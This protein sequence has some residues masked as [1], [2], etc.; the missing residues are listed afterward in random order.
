ML[1]AWPKLTIFRLR[2]IPVR[3]DATFLLVPVFFLGGLS[4]R[5]IEDGA[6][7][8]IVGVL[9]VFLSI[10]LHEIGHA[11]AAQ[12]YRVGVRDI[13]IGGF[14]GFTGLKGR[15]IPRRS[16]VR[17]L[18]MGPLANLAI[19]LALWLV[20]S[21]AFPSGAGL[22]GSRLPAAVGRRRRSECLR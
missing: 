16:L 3:I 7:L 5:R 14:Y 2:G 8:F 20:L 15:A 12:R 18:A 22:Q 19:F 17:I 10:L 21:L 13:V 4:W 9:G 6:P 1:R 11:L